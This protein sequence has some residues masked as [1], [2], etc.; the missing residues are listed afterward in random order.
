ME[1]TSQ[2]ICNEL[3]DFLGRLKTN[4]S[5][6]SEAHSLTLIQFHTLYI[7]MHGADSTSKIASKMHCDASNIT[8]VID[9]LVH[10]GLVTRKESPNDRRFKTLTLTTK[11]QA[12]IQSALNNLPTILGCDKL[13][14]TERTNLHSIIMKMG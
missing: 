9:R 10:Q 8:G 3:F 12:I 11:G 6:L 5:A 14:S 7:I 2:Q 1:V 13:T 4:L